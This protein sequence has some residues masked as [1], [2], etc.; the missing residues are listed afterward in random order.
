MTLQVDK[1]Y[2]NSMFFSFSD[3]LQNAKEQS[4]TVYG[5]VH[6]VSGVSMLKTSRSY[7]ITVVFSE[8]SILKE[9][10]EAMFTFSLVM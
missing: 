2:E 1:S 10:T 8:K 7:N 5:W 9:G 4:L 6:Q 3:S